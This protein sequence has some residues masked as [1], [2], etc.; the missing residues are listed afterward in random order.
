MK[1]AYIDKHS[2]IDSLI[3]R[4]DPRIKII[5]LAAFIL[6]VIFTRPTLFIAFVLYGTLM[7]ILI[8][9]SKI[10]LGFILKRSLVVIPFVLMI[11]IFIPFFKQGEVAGGY[12]FGTLKLT[13]TYE[14]LIIFWN[15][16]VKAYLC[17]LSMILLVSSTKL[18]GLLK[19]LERLKVPSVFIMVLSFMYRYLFVVQDELMKMRQ[20][21]ESRS[22]GGSRWFHTKVLANMLGV[23]FMRTYE[24]GENVYLAMC[25]RGFDGKIRTID[26]FQ[27]KMKDFCFLLIMIGVLT[28]IIILAN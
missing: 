2:N 28:G 18:S 7:A 21:K 17:N 16:L 12:S 26:G 1:H 5:C 23:L 3:H 11:A 13:V 9:L 6:F 10:P 27:L 25:S 15:I 14:G 8:L 22:V 20:A 24:R 4:L 19:A